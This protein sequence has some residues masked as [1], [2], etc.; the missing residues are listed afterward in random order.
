MSSIGDKIRSVFGSAAV[1]KNPA[2][3]DVFNGR[4]IPSFVKDYLVSSHIAPDGTFSRDGLSKFLDAHIPKDN[5]AI[6]ARLRRGETLTL[7]TRFV[8]T[9]NLALNKTRFEI[10]D[11][12]IKASDTLIPD[13][14]IEEYP[15]DLID[16]EKWG[17][18][19]IAYIAPSDG[20]RGHVELV[21]F[22][23]FRPMEKLD[24]NL[25]R[26]CRSQFTTEE[27]VDVLI[28]AMEYTPS[29]FS[30]DTQKMEFLT[31]LLPFIEPRLNMIELAPKGTGKSYVFGN[32]SKFVWLVSG[33]KV[34]RAKLVYDKVT[35]TP[36]IMRFYDMVA[37]DEIQSIRFSDDSEMQSFLK[38]YL[39]YGRA[40]IDNYEFMSECGLMLLGNIQLNNSNEPISHRYFDSLPNVFRETALLDR[41][42]GMI[43]GWLL[44]RVNV[45][46]ALQ[47]WTLNVEFFSEVLHQL[48]T[49]PVYSHIVD[50]LVAVPSGA[51]TRHTKAVKRLA[52]AY[53]KLLFPH[54]VSSEQIDRDDF[55]L[56]CLRPAIRRRDL[57]RQQ[58]SHIDAE[59]SFSKPM[60][61]YTVKG[62]YDGTI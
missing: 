23:P 54:V 16:G 50:E 32:L 35:K 60:P 27:W 61:N 55:N 43:E 36:G 22:K 30:N 18:L 14:L 59:L 7:L 38:G 20:E 3:Y 52:T 17:I 4:N 53:L 39:E 46:M 13:Y 19:K 29:S 47:D 21:K 41:F 1:Y 11:M 58:C 42:H 57:I 44:P 9:T 31:R 48:R 51:D 15:D 26:Q 5:S 6:V 12:G 37:F 34:S 8:I 62:L 56:Y 2:N 10:P 40:T 49:V 28:S 24:I 45:D 33:G 25:I